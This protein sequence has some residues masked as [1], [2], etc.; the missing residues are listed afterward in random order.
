MSELSYINL[1]GVTK[2]LAP[3]IAFW[4]TVAKHRPHWSPDPDGPAALLERILVSQG[5]NHPIGLD[6]E[7][8]AAAHR[9]SRK[10]VRAW[11]Y[12]RGP[13]PGYVT[14]KQ[15]ALIEM[16]VRREAQRLGL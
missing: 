6:V 8:W 1:E 10:L 15:A 9:M 14:H 12:A 13:L 7:D 5:T 2:L 3:E 4:R 11:F 16:A